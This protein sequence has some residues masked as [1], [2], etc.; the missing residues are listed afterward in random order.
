MC[1]HADIQPR[2]HL[3]VRFRWP[4]NNLDQTARFS[5]AFPRCRKLHKNQDRIVRMID[6]SVPEGSP[7]F[8]SRIVRIFPQL[9]SPAAITARTIMSRN[10]FILQIPPIF[11]FSLFIRL[12]HLETPGAPYPRRRAPT[13]LVG[14]FSGKQNDR[15]DHCFIF[16]GQFFHFCPVDKNREVEDNLSDPVAIRLLFRE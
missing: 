4:N 1:R 6:C 7:R 14:F 3:E 9:I 13:L 12:P 8:S 5:P 16:Q 2:T 15:L 10:R 11:V